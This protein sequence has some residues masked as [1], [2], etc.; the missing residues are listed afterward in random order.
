LI[1]PDDEDILIAVEFFS[2]DEEKTLFCIA[3]QRISKSD[4]QGK[5]GLLKKVF[6]FAVES[7]KLFVRF[8]IS[9]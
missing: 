4:G 8:W 9:Q 2:G 1:D 6:L 3:E 5:S 7:H